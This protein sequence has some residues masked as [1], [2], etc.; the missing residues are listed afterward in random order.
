MPNTT[1][2]RRI[3]VC[4]DVKMLRTTYEQYNAP[5][6]SRFSRG[7]SRIKVDI[8]S[9]APGT[10]FRGLAI[11]RLAERNLLAEDSTWTVREL[12]L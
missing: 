8:H 5:T 9:A 10:Q 12:E 1:E 11:E 2:Q 6:S 3:P 7:I 4:Q